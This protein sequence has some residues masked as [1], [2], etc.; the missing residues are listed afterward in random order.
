MTP[1]PKCSRQ[2]A[3]DALYC[4]QC[5]TAVSP[6][7]PAE[8][9]PEPCPACGGVVREAPSVVCLCSDCGLALGEAPAGAAAKAAGREAPADDAPP[10]GPLTPCPVCAAEY[11]VGSGL[12]GSCGIR[13]GRGT[14]PCARCGEETDEDKCA[15]GAIQTLQK[16]LGFVDPTVRVVCVSCK[17]LF[18]V[19]RA[20]CSDCGGRTL[21][22]DDLKARAARP[23]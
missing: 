9:H 23:G 20:E 2:N 1:C 17:Q 8:T 22:A 18:T 4:D 7:A 15:C 19:A 13:F 10:E 6:A 5:R 12:C 21:P 3:E 14:A 11:P 16:L